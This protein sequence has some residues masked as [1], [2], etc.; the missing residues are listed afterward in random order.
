MDDKIPRPHG[1]VTSQRAAGSEEL[2]RGASNP[3]DINNQDDEQVPI[4]QLI[5]EIKTFVKKGDKAKDK[6]EQYY[7][8][9]GIH[10]RTLKSQAPNPAAWEQLIKSRCGLSRSRAYDLIAIADGRKTVAELR[11]G[12]AE[13]MRKH[14]SRPSRDGQNPPVGEPEASGGRYPLAL[15]TTPVNQE[16]LNRLACRLIQT[17]LETA[18]ELY[19]VLVDGS[20]L[21]HLTRALADGIKAEEKGEPNGNGGMPSAPATAEDYPDMPHFLRRTPKDAAAS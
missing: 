20:Q 2:F 6:S 12:T 18:R 4:A 10:L 19:Q 5:K 1:S 8:A 21:Q 11:L 16:Q 3:S 17:D 15:V 13:R 9:A 7:V 14:R